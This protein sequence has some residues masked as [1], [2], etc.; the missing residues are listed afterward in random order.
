MGRN[1][2]LVLVRVMA[3]RPRHEKQAN[4]EGRPL[5]RVE[6]DSGD[7]P[8][9]TDWE[10]LAERASGAAFAVSPFAALQAMAKPV[11]IA[12]RLADDAEVHTLNRDYRDKDKPTNVLSFPM[13][14]PNDVPELEH[15][16]DPEILLGDIVLALETCEREAAEKGI[17]LAD[18]ATH[19]I[20]HGVLHLLGYDHMTENDATEMEAMERDALASLGLADPYQD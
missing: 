10:A 11:E 3:E 15:A 13:V 18:H 1:P 6:T 8:E 2:L 5:I 17:P 20:V 14:E 9:G 7:W 4:D 12:I 16:P 19:L